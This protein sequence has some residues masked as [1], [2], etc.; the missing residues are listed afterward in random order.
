MAEAFFNDLQ[1]GATGKQPRGMRVPQI[2]SPDTVQ[3]GCFTG[4]T[5]YLVPKPVGWNMAVGVACSWR[6]GVVHPT[7]AAPGAV[8]GVG[9]PAIL[10]PAFR[11]VVGGKGAVPV[12]AAF[13]VWLGHSPWGSGTG[14]RASCLGL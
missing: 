8:V 2:V 14:V 11:G 1:V 9:A 10:A 7:G 13:L 4:R 6:A 12:L 5:P 3:P